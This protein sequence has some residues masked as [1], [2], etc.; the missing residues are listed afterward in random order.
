MNVHC[1]CPGVNCRPG[2]LQEQSMKVVLQFSLPCVGDLGKRVRMNPSRVPGSKAAS[3]NSHFDKLPKLRTS[4]QHV[5]VYP[6]SS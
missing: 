1:A 2:I 6:T 5:G 4:G 3:N